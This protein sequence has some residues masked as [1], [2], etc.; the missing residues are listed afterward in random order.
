M[1]GLVPYQLAEDLVLFLASSHT[2]C[3]TQP[4]SFTLL[5]E[6]PEEELE[7]GGTRGGSRGG[8]ERGRIQRREDPEEDPEA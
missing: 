2:Q 6:D 7:E 8:P 4:V 1:E 5:P 3:G